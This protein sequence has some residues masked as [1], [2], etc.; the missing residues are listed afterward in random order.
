MDIDKTNST[1]EKLTKFLNNEFA[2]K[3][4]K[5]ILDFSKEYSDENDTPFLID[6]IYDTKLDEILESLCNNNDLVKSNEDA[7]KLAFLTPE[8]LNPDKYETLLK[9]IE[10]NEWKK[11][12]IKSSSAFKCSKCKMKRCSVS[13]KQILAGDEPLTTFVTC[14][15][16]GFSFSFH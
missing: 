1:I 3:V 2:I 6:S 7:Y 5:G 13:Q 4:E 9:K 10:I 12:E 8:E 14:L 11:K 15:E 16:C